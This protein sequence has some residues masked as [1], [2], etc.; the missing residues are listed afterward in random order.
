MADF[1]RFTLTVTCRQGGMP[2]IGQVR[3]QAAADMSN[4]EF[5][6]ESRGVIV[7][8]VSGVATFENVAI[9]GETTSPA[10]VTYKVTKRVDGERES[11][12]SYAF[13]GD[14]AGRTMDLASLTPVV[15]TPPS[16]TYN[17]ALLSQ[18]SAAVGLIIDSATEL[19]QPALIPPGAFAPNV[20][21]EAGAGGV[22]VPTLTFSTPVFG[23][24]AGTGRPYYSAS[25]A[26]PGE[27]AVLGADGSLTL[28]PFRAPAVPATS[29][30]LAGEVSARTLADQTLAAQVATS[31]QIVAAMG[32]DAAILAAASALV[33]SALTT[34]TGRAAAFALVLGGG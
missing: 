17:Y 15:S 5:T 24:E 11:Y 19:L 14:L 7:K 26:S 33:T 22:A 8:L 12:A 34:A 2:Q 3:L 25:G 30:D 28:L 29:V 31:V 13:T 32:T 1:D 23:I 16:P 18:L 21:V 27:E 6:E 20:S 4:G 10:G 9:P